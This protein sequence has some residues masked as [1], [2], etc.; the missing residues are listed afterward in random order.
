M[1]RLHLSRR[2]LLRG[3]GG[4]AFS[5]PLLHAMQPR[6]RADA[7]PPK[8][9]LVMYTPNG[10]VPDAFWPTGG[11]HDF[12]LSPILQPL[13]RHRQ[14][15]LVLGG[16]D[17]LSALNGPGDAHQKGTGQCLTATELL[18]G[19]FPG[20][21]G[22]QAGWAG[23]ISIDQHVAAGI[24]QD[25]ALTS[26]ELGVAVQGSDVYS[27][28]SYRGAG[29][30]LPPEN[31]P[32]AAYQRLFGEAL[33][34]PAVLARRQA[35][36]QL[37]LD[38]V[39]DEFTTLSA[40]LGRDD[41]DKLQTHMLALDDVRT[42]LTRP[43]VQLGGTCQ[44]LDQGTPLDHDR[45]ANMPEIGR[46][47]MDLIALAL[48]CD[49]TRVASLMWSH[50]A[51]DHVYS[52]L[53]EDMREGH[54]LLAHKG[55]EDR[56]KVEQ[57]VRINA[58]YADQI[59]YLIDRLKAMPEG[60]GTVF[61]RT[62]ILWTNEQ[63]KGNNHDRRGMPYLLA[64]SAGGALRTGRYVTQPR[65]TGHNQLMVSLLHALDVPGETFGNPAYGTGELPGLT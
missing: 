21:A 43:Q 14:D 50:S 30:P 47:Q 49:L 55:D 5:L 10:T 23:G 51:A 12:E 11:E 37:A 61:D 65:E 4:A 8:R 38:L 7:D 1:S 64:G 53:G 39:A 46:L 62:V 28:I 2:A 22:E 15:L 57:N 35:R 52:W 63:A 18:E 58:W 17:M 54:H 31:S 16:V 20:D 9:F 24:G 19:D 6:A 40:R 44:T 25:T 32:Y 3:L 42:R 26:L 36:R 41:R 13:Q 45:I 27:R 33:Q 56:V 59:A 48:A 60:D 34:D 29:Q